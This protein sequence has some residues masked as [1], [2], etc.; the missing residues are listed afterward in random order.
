MTGGSKVAVVGAAGAIG[1]AVGAELDRR[2]QPY[3]VVGRDR[4]KLD[5]LFSGKAEIIPA[6]VADPKQAERALA[7]AHTVIYAIGVPYPQFELHPILM[8]N[9]IEAAQRAGVARLAVISSVYSYGA[10]R[11]ERVSEDH[12][13][14][15]ETRKGRRRKEQ[16]DIAL[17]ADRPALLRT[18]V[19]RLPDF[20]GPHAEASLA[21]QVFRG[22]L[23]NKP[24]NWIG[25]PDV[26]HEFVFVPDV[27]PV[28]LD[29]ASREDSFGQA[30]NFG[31]PGTITGREFIAEA[32]RAAGREPKFR[33]VGPLALRLG[34]IFSPLLRELV[35]MHY[36][37]TTPVIL[38]DTKLRRHLGTVRKT[39]Y[40]D[41][42]RQ[43]MS[44]YRERRL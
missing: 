25:S 20:Y 44:W 9:T 31:G 11:T 22:A 38:D 39:P 3:S 13:R 21:D 10:P 15:P 2:G 30:W 42:I 23:R 26:A 1:A 43:T 24:A 14:E 36:L 6:D 34:G 16:E 32:Y 29:L 19:L 7:G 5:R 40:P 27:G 18:L 33:A 4:T 8:R 28:V 17:A 12:L 37:A 41:G 35:E